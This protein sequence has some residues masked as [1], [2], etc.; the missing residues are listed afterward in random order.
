MNAVD[1]GTK[2]NLQTRLAGSRSLEEFDEF[3]R[4]LKNRVGGQVREVFERERRRPPGERRLV[5][6]V[7]DGLGQ[8]RRAFN[9]HFYR[10]ARLVQGVPIACRQ[11][12]LRFNNNPIERHNQDIKQRYKTMRHFKSLASAEAFLDLRRMVYNYVRTHQGLGR[13][14]AEAAGIR[15]DLGKNRLLGLIRLSSGA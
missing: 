6:F 15:L 13:T 4:E 2:F 14:P 7:S 11:Y 9:R 5:T 10:V 8:Y 1:S 3:F 12:G